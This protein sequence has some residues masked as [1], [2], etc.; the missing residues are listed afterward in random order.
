[1]IGINRFV[2][3]ASFR[4]CVLTALPQKLCFGK[5]KRPLKCAKYAS[6]VYAKYA[7]NVHTDV[8]AKYTLLVYTGK[9]ISMRTEFSFNCYTLI[10]ASMSTK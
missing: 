3:K 2:S 10:S 7:M 9:A 8:Y 4:F 1:M 5:L 6:T